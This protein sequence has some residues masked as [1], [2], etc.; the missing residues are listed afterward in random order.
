MNIQTIRRKN[1]KRAHRL[2]REAVQ[3]MRDE[4]LNWAEVSWAMPT[5]GSDDI[6]G[7]LNEMWKRKGDKESDDDDNT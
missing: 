1:I 2:F 6:D 3:R 4:G 7:W 5:G